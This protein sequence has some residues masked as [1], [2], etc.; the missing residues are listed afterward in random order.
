MGLWMQRGQISTCSSCGI[1]LLKKI[2]DQLD[3]SVSA[4]FILFRAVQMYTTGGMRA[5]DPDAAELNPNAPT[6][7]PLKEYLIQR[8][9]PWSASKY[10]IVPFDVY[11][12]LL[13]QEKLN[14][15]IC[16]KC[17]MYWSSKAATNRHKPYHK[18]NEKIPTTEPQNQTQRNRSQMKSAL[19]RQNEFLYL[20]IF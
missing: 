14:R 18:E 15:R 5:I 6:F 12:R 4:A 1:P 11:C 9:V 16:R 2:P 8:S 20:K 10:T 13:M 19:A 7:S 17:H 3:A